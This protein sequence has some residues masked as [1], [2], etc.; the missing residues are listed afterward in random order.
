MAIYMK[1]SSPYIKGGV[2]TTGFAGQ[3]NITSFQ[4][5]IGR[6]VGSPIGGAT[7]REASTPSVSEIVLT[8]DED[9]ASGKL[10]QEAYSGA[11]KATAVL[12]F[13]RTDAKGG[14]AFLEYTLTNVMLSS[15]S[16]SAGGDGKPTESFSLNFTKVETK[17]IAQKA[18][19]TAGDSFPVTYDLSTQSMS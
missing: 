17:F 18:D 19:G 15:W 2:T 16:T 3:T 5:G 1:Y 9:E 13:V 10:L 4:W 6:G 12:S 7:N 11:G 14:V 8:K